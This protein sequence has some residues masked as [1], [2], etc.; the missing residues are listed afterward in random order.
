MLVAFFTLL[1]WMSST[2]PPLHGTG[3]DLP[4]SSHAALMS[5]ARRDDALVIAILRDGKV[6]LDTEMVCLK[7]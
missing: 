5:G 1:A 7:H 3:I 2:G 6:F 4:I